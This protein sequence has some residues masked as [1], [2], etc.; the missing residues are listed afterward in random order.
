MS[1]SLHPRCL[2]CRNCTLCM[3]DA[4]G[5]NSLEAK[6]IQ[7]LKLKC[8]QVEST[9]DGKKLIKIKYLWD[10]NKLKDV[11]RSSLQ[12]EQRLKSLEFKLQKMTKNE[13]APVQVELEEILNQGLQKGFW[14]IVS[15]EELGK[16]KMIQYSYPITM[17]LKEMKLPPQRVGWY[18]TQLLVFLA[19][20][21]SMRQCYVY[22]TVKISSLR[23]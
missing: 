8:I 3:L 13:G 1:H 11:C 12:A 7:Y 19:N 21:H 2:A 14:D 17:L 23:Y 20:P 4:L 5:R 9:P 10:H 22:Q 6:V 18:M 16:T 15:N